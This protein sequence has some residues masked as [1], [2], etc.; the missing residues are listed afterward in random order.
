MILF[1]LLFI[2]FE[3]HASPNASDQIT[4]LLRTQDQA[5]LDAFAPGDRKVWDHA[6]A[7]DAVYVDEN[8]A[9]MSRSEF[10][11]QLEPLPAGAS[12]N[13]S[14]CVAAPVSDSPPQSH[15]RRGTERA[16]KSPR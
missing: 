14:T 1:L 8:G 10:L 2:A 5:L 12:G 7:A 16:R 9:I 4:E 15:C 11:K 6:L 3:L 13:M